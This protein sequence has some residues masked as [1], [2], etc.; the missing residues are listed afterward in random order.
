M[1]KRTGF[2]ITATYFLPID[3]KNFAAQAA[4]FSA[5]AD[6]ESTGKLPADFAGTLLTVKAKQGSADVPDSPTVVA[7]AQGSAVS[8]AGDEPVIPAVADAD[9]INKK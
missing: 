1:T 4:T 7:L 5:I 3:K 8:D 2:L 6:I 9:K